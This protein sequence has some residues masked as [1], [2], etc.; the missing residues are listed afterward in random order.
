MIA[1]VSEG[2]SCSSTDE[3]YIQQTNQFARNLHLARTP[4]LPVHNATVTPSHA[5]VRVRDTRRVTQRVFLPRVIPAVT[6]AR[7]RTTG[8]CAGPRRMR[9][10]LY[11]RQQLGVYRR[12]SQPP[13]HRPACRSGNAGLI[14]PEAG[15]A[16]LTSLGPAETLPEQDNPSRGIAPRR[17]PGR[18]TPEA[19]SPSH[20]FPPACP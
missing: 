3:V 16:Q 18:L 10:S 12:F 4:G 1:V 8:K 9:W 7:C 17:G 2:G 14:L 15:T 20:P 5:C 11:W 13:K 19:W 6:H